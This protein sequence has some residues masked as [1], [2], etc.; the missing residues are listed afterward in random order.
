MS[1]RGV[2]RSFGGA[3]DRIA[4]MTRRELED[5]IDQV[6]RERARDLISSPDLRDVAVPGSIPRRTV[7]LPPVVD[8][9]PRNGTATDGDEV[10]YRAAPGVLWHF[11]YRGSGEPAYPWEF[12][13]GPRLYT[14]VAGSG[15]TT[16]STTYTTL[17]SATE[18]VTPL[19][20]EYDFDWSVEAFNA[21]V[22]SLMLS[23]LQIGSE[24]LTGTT[25]GD[26]DAARSAAHVASAGV[27]GVGARR[28]IVTAPKTVCRLVHRVTAGT[29]TF[30]MRHLK[31]I[32]VRVGRT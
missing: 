19:A 6:A 23:A 13:G 26:Q 29:G 15:E 2:V 3:P 8:V 30:Q 24:T 21:T 11:R 31:M 32:P 9:L 10:Y 12:V 22:G 5:M 17:T 18:F 20:G 28:G 4:D 1:T 16:A 14:F 7:D 25:P 27:V